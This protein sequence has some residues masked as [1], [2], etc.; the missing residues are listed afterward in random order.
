MKSKPNGP[1]GLVLDEPTQSSDTHANPVG[2][3]SLSKSTKKNQK[4][5]EKKKQ[6]PKAADGGINDD[7]TQLAQEMQVSARLHDTEEQTEERA[8]TEKKLRNLLKRL[9]AIDDL[10]E[11]ITS[12]ELKKPEAQQLEK[13]ERRPEVVAQIEQLQATLE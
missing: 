13:I 1:V 2:G 8:A 11:R 3:A 12:G 5:K 6:Q 7:V 10:R 9:K 4:R